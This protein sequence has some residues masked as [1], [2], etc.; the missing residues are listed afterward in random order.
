MKKI[1][2]FKFKLIQPQS[3][4]FESQCLQHFIASEIC[5]KDCFRLGG[6]IVQWLAYLLTDPAALG[7]SPSFTEF[8]SEE[9]ISDVAKVIQQRWLEENGLWLENVDRTHL[10][11]ASGSGKPVLQKDRIKSTLWP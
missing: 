4:G 11:L 1:E 7:S 9:K 2:D 8:F 3:C 5:G 6:S 10:V